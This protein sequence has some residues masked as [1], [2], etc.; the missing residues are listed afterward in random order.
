[1]SATGRGAE[2]AE[3]DFYPTPAWC[4]HRLLDAIVSRLDLN[5]DPLWFEPCVGDGAIIRATREWF[6]LHPRTRTMTPPYWHAIDISPRV[7]D[8]RSLGI[9][10]SATADYTWFGGAQW[11]EHL[12]TR[13]YR[14]SPSNPPY[15]QSLDFVRMALTHCASVAY[16]LRVNWL[17]SEER[18]DFLRAHQPELFVLPNRPSFDGEG[19]D[20]TEY[21][22][23]GWGEMF[24]PGRWSLLAPTPIEVR[25][26]A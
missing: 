10:A 6:A 21:A 5:S 9:V 14:F 26:A 8:A 22:W 12:G 7:D 16:L 18:Q 4:V 3:R 15:G 13:R 24:E 23:F 11:R 20:A 2:R 19:T 1:M 17:G 25:R